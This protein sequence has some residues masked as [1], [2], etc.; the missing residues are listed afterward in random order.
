[1]F[2]NNFLNIIK[3]K[4]I[5]FLKILLFIY[6]YIYNLIILRLFYKPYKRQSIK[7]HT[8]I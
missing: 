8:N 5:F 1:M 7:I 3:I 2:Q 6:I 4:S